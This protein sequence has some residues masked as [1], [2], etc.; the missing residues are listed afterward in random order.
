[1]HNSQPRA[2]CSQQRCITGALRRHACGVANERRARRVRQIVA[3]AAA[4][5]LLSQLWALLKEKLCIGGSLPGTPVTPATSENRR[6]HVNAEGDGMLLSF[7]GM[8]PALP[9]IHSSQQLSGVLRPLLPCSKGRIPVRSACERRP[10]MRHRCR[11]NGASQRDLKGFLKLRLIRGSWFFHKDNA[12][13]T[14]CVSVC[15]LFFSAQCDF[16]LINGMLQG[17]KG[18]SK[19]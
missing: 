14:V 4:L 10:L 2:Y 1:M 6:C 13:C 18:L 11:A 3:A 7:W 17:L 5:G 8:G 12:G 9:C 16:C 19:L 15:V